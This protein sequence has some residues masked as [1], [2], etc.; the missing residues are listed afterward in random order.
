VKELP[1]DS[2]RRGVDE[3]E[4]PFV[5]E[6]F[7]EFLFRDEMVLHQDF[8]Q[9]L[10]ASGFLLDAD[11]L[12]EIV[13]AEMAQFDQEVAGGHFQTI[14]DQNPEE[15]GG[16]DDVQLRENRRQGHRSGKLRLNPPGIP[17][18]IFADIAVLNEEPGDDRR[19]VGHLFRMVRFCRRGVAAGDR[20]TTMKGDR[21]RHYSACSKAMCRD[22]SEKPVGD[23][24][25]K[26]ACGTDS[27]SFRG[28]LQPMPP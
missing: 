10:G 28:L 3:V 6:Y 15:L 13:Y 21:L 26:P 16:G 17:D 2:G 23:A 22:E 18:L 1:I 5:R 7:E 4:S 11:G 9:L 8:T 24:S 12:G 14:G 19:R 27:D 25:T 20:F